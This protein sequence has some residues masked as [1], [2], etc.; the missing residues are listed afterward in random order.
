MARYKI[1]PKVAYPCDGGECL[2]RLNLRKGEMAL[3]FGLPLVCYFMIVFAP[4][5]ISRYNRGRS[6][7]GL[8]T[9]G[10]W[11]DGGNHAARAG[12]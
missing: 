5:R 10:R 11:I 8:A 4:P 12:G 2:I 1:G 9:N 6:I 7:S 3:Q